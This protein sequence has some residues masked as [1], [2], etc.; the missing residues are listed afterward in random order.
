MPRRGGESED[1]GLTVAPKAN[2]QAIVTREGYFRIP[3]RQR[4]VVCLFVGDQVLLLGHRGTS[5][6][7]VHPRA[8]LDE[9]CAASVN[10]AGAV[11]P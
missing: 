11:R 7:V 10:L 4:R 6:L 8:T 5:R 9:L 1:H 2:G 3:Y